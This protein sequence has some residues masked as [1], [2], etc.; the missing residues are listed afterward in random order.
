M[1]KIE[2]LRK[3]LEAARKRLVSKGCKYDPKESNLMDI[4]PFEI[5]YQKAIEDTFPGYIWWELTHYWD[6][7]DAMA[8]GDYNDETIIDGIIS[9]IDQDALSESLKTLDNG[10]KVEDGHTLDEYKAKFGAYYDKGEL[11]DFSEDDFLDGAIDIDPLMT[12]WKIV[13]EDGDTRYYETREIEESACRN[14]LDDEDKKAGKTL[15]EGT[16]NFPT[17]DNFPLCVF[18]TVDEALD[19]IEAQ[20]GY[21]NQEDY[22]NKDGEYDNVAYQDAVDSFQQRWFDENKICVLEYE[23]VDS[24]RDA[25]DDFNSET[26]DIVH[27][28]E[29]ED[30]E[31]LD[32]DLSYLE[33]IKLGLEPGHYSG[34]Y[35]D[36]KNEDYLDYMTRDFANEQIDRI[37]TFLD[38]IVKEYHLTKLGLSYRFS[39]GET[40]FHL[41]D[42]AKKGKKDRARMIGN[43]EAEQTFF[44][45]A[46]GTCTACAL[47]EAAE[48]T[49]EELFDELLAL[50]EFDLVKYPDGW[51]VHDQQ[52]VN[53]GGIEGDRFDNAKDI[54]DRLEIYIYDYLIDNGYEF[55]IPELD[56]EW[57]TVND[58]SQALRAL[59]KY[60]DQLGDYSY[61]YDW[62][63]FMI[64]R[65]E[66]VD[67]E[68]CHHEEDDTAY[69]D[70]NEVEDYFK[71]VGCYGFDGDG[72][73]TKGKGAYCIATEDGHIV[74][75]LNK[76]VLDEIKSGLSKDGLS[77]FDTFGGYYEI[78]FSGD[79][80]WEEAC[81]HILDGISRGELKGTFDVSKEGIKESKEG[82]TISL[83]TIK[84]H[85]RK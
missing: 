76:D 13:D 46:N 41:I 72:T 68:K 78:E 12:Y 62:F 82:K 30:R 79:C 6:I 40:G 60:K 15:T 34:T 63:D 33:D 10:A 73:F 25:L 42:E 21:P 80:N 35:I 2:T 3:E 16:S 17:Y 66:G 27:Y 14:C 81:P 85:K 53:L 23:E 56:D 58:A 22:V 38:K 32:E 29:I 51:G 26:F 4:K 39:N 74:H 54:I 37:N 50:L 47:H 36:I 20:D 8:S 31:G 77:Q 5:A 18:Y 11:W 24:L 28:N 9:H 61:L 64:N 71:S 69:G 55:G 49:D 19:I 43:P 84:S 48:K 44:N 57:D 70:S 65:S 83:S 1:D 45:V 7:F 75:S 52:G 67:L 59:G